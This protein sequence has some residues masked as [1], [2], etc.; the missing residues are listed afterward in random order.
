MDWMALIDSML[1]QIRTITSVYAI[2]NVRLQNQ[3][4]ARP[5]YLHFKE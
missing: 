5:F 4:I 3:R 1:P 2:A